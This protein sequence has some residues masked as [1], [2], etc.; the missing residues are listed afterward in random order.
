MKAWLK[1]LLIMWAVMAALLLYLGIGAVLVAEA[2][3]HHSWKLGLVAA[4][5]FLFI[6]TGMVAWITKEGFE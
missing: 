2:Q 1:A 3:E 6:F 4:S 5:W